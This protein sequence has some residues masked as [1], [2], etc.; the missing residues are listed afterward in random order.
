MKDNQ[1]FSLS[2][3]ESVRKNGKD[4]SSLEWLDLHHRTKKEEREQMV[5][6]LRLK[7]G[8]IVLDLACGPG[9][10]VPLFANKVKPNGKVLGIDIDPD[11]I[12]YAK[13]S[14]SENP[15]KKIIDFQEGDFYAIPSGE[16]SFDVVI[17]GNCFAYV[18]NVTKVMEELKRV[19][20]PGGRIVGKHWD[21]TNTIFYPIDTRFLL[22]V[23][24]AA[25]NAL[26]GKLVDC[27]IDEFFGKKMHGI[28][29]K[30]GLN[31]VSTK[32]YAIQR[33][34]PL[35]SE[36]KL[37]IKLRANWLSEIAAPCMS[38]EDFEQWNS[39]FD[40]TS[41]SYILDREEFFF[42]TLEM[43]TEGVFSGQTK[44]RK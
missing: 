28:F 29:L 26:E 5:E 31:N 36:A 16:S 15:L 44:N 17:F 20:K 7:P 4:L 12:D 41:N 30:A 40:P 24:A 22:K 8:D 14:L 27:P 34:Y 37:Y 19:S 1:K 42:L 18:D 35:S 9:F 2:V 38:R 6:D 11:F 13:K 32:T 3:R 43:Q 33:V 39:Y 25:A 21:N 10:W 23:Q